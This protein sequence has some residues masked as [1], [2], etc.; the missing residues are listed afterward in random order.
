VVP[1][2][3]PHGCKQYIRGKSIRF[4]YKFWCGAT[5]LGYISWFQPYQGKHPNTK[6]EEYGFGASIVLQF[7]E[8]H[9]EAHH[10]QYHFVF[11]NFFTNFALL[12]KLSSMG[13]GTVRK[14]G[15]GRAPLE[16][17]VALKRKERGT[18]DYRIDGKGNIVCRWN[19]NNV[20]TAVSS[21][22]GIDPLCLVN[23]YSQKLKTRSKFSSQSVRASADARTDNSTA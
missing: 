22:A 2:F 1:S 4:G 23:L 14:G 5:R 20:V 8:A 17:D 3:G 7:S 15:N 6:H 18:F 21:G 10:G 13:T 16:S 12:D 9:K 11:D 19:D